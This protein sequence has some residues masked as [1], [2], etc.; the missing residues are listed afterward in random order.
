MIFFNYFSKNCL[1]LI[2]GHGLHVD[3][4]YGI[5][6]QGKIS[7]PTDQL[8]LSTFTHTV[9]FTVLGGGF[10]PCRHL[11]PSSGREQSVHRNQILPLLETR[12]F[13]VRT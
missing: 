13:V 3:E 1:P 8:K 12:S 11:K 2:H 10:T 5:W 9:A 7:V 4:T 6:C